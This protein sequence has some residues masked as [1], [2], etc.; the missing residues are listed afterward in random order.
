MIPTITNHEKKVSFARC[1]ENKTII[2]LEHDAHNQIITV[3]I[4]KDYTLRMYLLPKNYFKI[5]L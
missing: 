1:C 3:K 5:L 2:Y 4:Q